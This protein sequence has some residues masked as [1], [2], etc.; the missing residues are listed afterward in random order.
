[1]SLARLLPTARY[2]NRVQTH[3]VNKTSR[4]PDRI[5]AISSMGLVTDLEEV[6]ILSHHKY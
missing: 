6:C 2:F 3:I 1:M 5:Q 4:G